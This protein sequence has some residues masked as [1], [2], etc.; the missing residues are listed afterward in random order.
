[1][2]ERSRRCDRR[3]P[4]R[5]ILTV[6]GASRPVNNLLRK[7]LYSQGRILG[8]D[9]GVDLRR[10][11]RAV[12]ELLL[13]EA[14]IEVRSAL[15]PENWT[16]LEVTDPAPDPVGDGDTCE[17]RTLQQKGVTAAGSP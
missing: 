8:Q 13:N 17:R 3:S 1:M 16:T 11:D 10:L 15:I 2:G 9:V 4:E 14:N 12:A 5:R 6:S 7:V